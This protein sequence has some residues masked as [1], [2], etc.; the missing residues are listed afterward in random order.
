MEE[1]KKE[2]PEGVQPI[3]GEY[4]GKPVLRIPTVDNPSPDTAWHWFT[5]GKAKAKAIVKHY[6]AIKKFA[7]G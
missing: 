3:I 7:E 6:D 5:F 4:Q 1:E 2:A